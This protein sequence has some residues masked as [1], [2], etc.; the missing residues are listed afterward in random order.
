MPY[1]ILLFEFLIISIIQGDSGPGPIDP[2][3]YIVQPQQSYDYYGHRPTPAQ[4]QLETPSPYLNKRNPDSN[5]YLNSQQSY[6]SIASA[7]GTNPT[8]TSPN[9]CRLHIN[10]PSKSDYI[11]SIIKV[12][13]FFVLG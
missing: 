11:L 1:F 7:Y 3:T 12:S 10:C 8:K 6:S 9:Q 2:N 5:Q 13:L 4:Q